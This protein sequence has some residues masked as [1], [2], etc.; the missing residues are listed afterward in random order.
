M[1]K[2]EIS[3]AS[4]ATVSSAKDTGK[5]PDRLKMCTREDLEDWPLST[6]STIGK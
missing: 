5:T 2:V 4:M 1:Q 3:L 6:S